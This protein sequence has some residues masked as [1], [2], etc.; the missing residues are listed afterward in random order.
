MEKLVTLCAVEAAQQNNA[1]RSIQRQTR[2]S[3]TT[4]ENKRIENELEHNSIT[5]QTLTT[6]H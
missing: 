4:S 6:K 5:D 2:S 1:D 3:D